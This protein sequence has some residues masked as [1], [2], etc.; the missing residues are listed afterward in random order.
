MRKSSTPDVAMCKSDS[1][2]SETLIGRISTASHSDASH[3]AAHWSSH[4]SV[5]L[6]LFLCANYLNDET[7]TVA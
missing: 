1:I 6:L 4:F 3:F 7:W 2:I 5:L